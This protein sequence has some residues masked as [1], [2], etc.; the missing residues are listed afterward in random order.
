MYICWSSQI[1]RR[2]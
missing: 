1:I 2:L